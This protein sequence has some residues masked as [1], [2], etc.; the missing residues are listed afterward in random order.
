MRALLLVRRGAPLTAALV[1]VIRKKGFEPVVLSS[2]P[3]D[4]GTKFRAMCAG[5]DVR[6]VVSAGVAVT[7]EEVMATVR[8]IED[9]AFAIT[10]ADSQRTVMA[11]AN[12]LLG[13]HDVTP[14]ALRHALDKHL[15]RKRLF[16]LGLSR[17]RPLRVA[18]PELRRRIEAGEQYVVKPRRGV[19]SLCVGLVRTWSDVEALQ[20]VYERGPGDG[21]MMAEYFTDN[22]LIAEGFCDG[23]EVS[24]EVIRQDGHDRVSVDHEKTLLDFADGTVLE[25]GL[26]SPVVGITADEL[27]AARGVADEAMDALGLDNGCYHVELRIDQTGRPEVIE[28]N[29]RVGGALVWDSV[30][31]QYDRSL[32]DDWIDV[33]AGKPVAPMAPRKCGTYM[34]LAF[35]VVGKQVTGIDQNPDLPEP[36]VYGESIAPG[37]VALANR[38]FFG[39]D[40]LWTTELAT[41]RDQVARLV[42]EEYCLF[43][44][45]RGLTGK[46]VLLALE[47]DASTWNA[48]AAAPEDVD[49][50]VCH[51]ERIEATDEYRAARDRIGRLVAVPSWDSPDA[52]ASV[53]ESCDGAPI[54]DILG[55]RTTHVVADQVRNA[56]QAPA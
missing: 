46:P 1:D 33:L 10:M 16:E 17:L 8:D 44:Y 48:I 45:A 28:I 55:P 32:I 35:P 50:V 43:A 29:P 5:L 30:R 41:H 19:A 11:E 9:C 34:Q 15:M 23:R 38:E 31:L 18:D 39:A 27:D 42:A 36:E 4:G 37:A 25:R 21:D 56:M 13:A 12:G 3:A 2:L 6:C 40:A 53:L 24:F 51:Q 49:V 26:A 7:S 22:E 54:R 52:L 14:G 47:P 20:A